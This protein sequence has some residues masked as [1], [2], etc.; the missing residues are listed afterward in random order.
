MTTTV[1]QPIIDVQLTNEGNLVLICASSKLNAKGAFVMNAAQSARILQ[2]AGVPNVYALKHLV[3]ISNGTSKMSMEVENCKAGDV[4]INV[5]DGT[6]GT[7]E[8]DWIKLSNHGIELG[9]AAQQKLV[10]ASLAGAFSNANNFVQSAPRVQAPVAAVV[11]ANDTDLGIKGSNESAS[12]EESP[13][14]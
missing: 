8:K 2:R 10:D 13:K 5:K 14:V 6:T 12:T 4:W 11:E 1:K 3:G 7:Y 9:W